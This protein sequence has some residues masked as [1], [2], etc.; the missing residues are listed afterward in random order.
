MY[1]NTMYNI[2]FV[3]GVFTL[4]ALANISIL[5]TIFAPSPLKYENI[6]FQTDKRIY[7]TH[8]NFT[9]E[10]NQCS[11]ENTPISVVSVKEIYNPSQGT[12]T[13]LHPGSR[14]VPPGCTSVDVSYAEL[15]PD[16]LPDGVY[17]LRGV[18]TFRGSLKT[19]DVEWQT[20][21]FTF[22]KE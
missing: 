2:V 14:I 8:D 15:F 6:P 1:K 9:M 4:I 19:V 3:L 13:A 5:I 10:V 16:N 7:T 18:T 12:I 17:L 20:Q 22:R 11:Q 21:T